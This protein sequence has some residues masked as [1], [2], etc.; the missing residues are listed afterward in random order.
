MTAD[1]VATLGSES[2]NCTIRAGDTLSRI[3]GRFL[4][5]IYQFHILAR[6]ND[7]AF[8]KQVH[9]GQV[10][11]VPGKAPPPSAAPEPAAKPAPV[12]KRAA[13][14]KATTEGRKSAAEPAA[15]APTAAPPPRLR[16]RRSRRESGLMRS[17]L[18]AMKAGNK[19]GPT[20]PSCRRRDSI[21]TTAKPRPKPRN[22]GR[23]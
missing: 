5:D 12:Q 2:F 6:Y 16:R 9:V 10:I 18:Q 11:K 4:G 7:I 15:P 19:E 1:P 8:P 23:G 22:C 14:D 21:P 13:E 17:G 3:A 20:R